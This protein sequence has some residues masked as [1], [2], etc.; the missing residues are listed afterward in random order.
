MADTQREGLMTGT[1][2][3][4]VAGKVVV[5]TGAGRGIGAATA[6]LLA[7][8]GARVVLGSRGDHELAATA[9][10]IADAGGQVAYQRADVTRPQDLVALAALATSQFGRL[11]VLASIAGVAINAPLS[12]GELD[13][14]DQMID[15]NLRGV[16]HGI[17]AAL[18]VFRA[19]GSGHFIT[20]ASTAAYKWVPG[21]AVY[22]ATKS[23]VR[24]LC[25]V[26]RQE[27]APENLRCTLISP[28]FTD[29]DFISSTRD[30]GE[31]A[32]LTARRDA[33]A[34]P[35]QAVAETIAF[36]IAQPDSVDI[37]EVIV[38]PTIQP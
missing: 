25:E 18:P 12:S 7:A 28:G 6:R 19:Q 3:G 27:L 5:I 11:D 2:S 9:E 4:Q 30:P 24:A 22:A 35:P 20:V 38:R 14:W 23:A 29:T 13:D 36:T 37:G 32:S 31:L 10:A 26:L 1:G 17:A 16:L 33:M 34:M 15:V 21:Q 8:R